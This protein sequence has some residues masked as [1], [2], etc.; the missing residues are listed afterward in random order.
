MSSDF[1]MNKVWNKVVD[2]VKLK[3]I[4]PTLWITLEAAI[5]L[6]VEDDTLVVG[7]PP[8]HTHL[9]GHLTVS[10]HK[11]AIEVALTEFA[12]RRLNLRVIE[13][14]TLQD[15]AHVKQKETHIRE[16][17]ETDSAKKKS[18]AAIAKEWENLFETAGRR[19][20]NLHLRGLPQNRAK[21]VGEMIKRISETMD[22]LIPEGTPSDEVTERSLARVIERVGAVTETPPTWIA[23]ELLRYR[24]SRKGP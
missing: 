15:W 1:D 11:N 21:Y 24:A 14:E 3:V 13:G 18:A 8:S 16:M 22:E 7:F 5:P 10:E 9:R 2:A 4:H 6:V 19:Y 17:R 20:A 12:G 23:L